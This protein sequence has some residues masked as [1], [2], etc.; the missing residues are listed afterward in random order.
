MRINLMDQSS[1][2]CTTATVRSLALRCPSQQSNTHTAQHKHFRPI[3]PSRLLL[4]RQL[5]LNELHH[6]GHQHFGAAL[7]PNQNCFTPIVSSLSP[8]TSHFAHTYTLSQDT[9]THSRYTRPQK[10]TD[11][12]ATATGYRRSTAAHTYTPILAHT[13]ASLR[14]IH[15]AMHCQQSPAHASTQVEAGQ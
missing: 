12:N 1:W 10:H 15:V 7:R 14:I 2:N 13:H 5:A 4:R 3:D 11:N 6:L 8:S 9:D